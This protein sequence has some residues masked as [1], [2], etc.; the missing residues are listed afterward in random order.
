MKLRK[1]IFERLPLM[2]EEVPSSWNVK[3]NNEFHFTNDRQL[4]NQR[5]QGIPFYEG[6]MIHQYDAFYAVP[7]FLDC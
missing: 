5:K 3:L 6:K 2:G 4:L 7:Q 1:R